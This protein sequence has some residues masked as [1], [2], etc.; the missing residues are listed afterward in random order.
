MTLHDYEMWTIAP[1][2]VCPQKTADRELQS[3]L[4]KLLAQVVCWRC[5]GPSHTVFGVAWPANETYCPLSN[6][7]SYEGMSDGN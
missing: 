3:D 5:G 4:E 2:I 1:P 6:R 7:G